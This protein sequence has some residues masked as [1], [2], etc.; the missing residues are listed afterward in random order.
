MG[1]TT[2]SNFSLNGHDHRNGVNGAAGNGELRFP[3]DFLWGAATAATQVEGHVRNEWTD[4]VARDG[5]N[6]RIAC[7]S[8]H[9]YP[10][11]VEWLTKLGVKGYR[12]GIEWSRLQPEPHGP[13]DPTELARYRDML[14]RLRAAGIEPM[15]VLHHFSN[16]PWVSAQGG[17]LSRKTVEAFTDYAGKLV[18]ALRDRVRIW[19]TFNEPDTYASNTYLLGEFP[20]FHKARLLAFRRVI[21]NMANAHAEACRLIRERG[22]GVGPVEVGFSKNWTWFQAYQGIFPWD[23]CLAALS[24]LVFNS[25][26]LRAFLGNG[27]ERASTFLGLNYYGRVRFHHGR[28]MVPINGCHHHELNGM[29]VM[30]DD[31]FERHPEG[32]E[33]VLLELRRRYSLP[34]YLTEHGAASEDEEFRARDLRENLAALHR[35]LGRGV[36]VRGFFYWSLLDNFEWQFGYSKKFGLVSVD[37]SRED[38][39]RAMKPLGHDY[40]RLCRENML[41]V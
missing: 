15:V 24:H 4:V 27:R 40:A 1:L 22:S 10:E 41:R 20:P 8:Y 37:F 11:D 5:S 29:G 32:L 28:A 3:K 2:A 13:L 25:F 12:V 26:V 14:D 39:P 23:Q 36:D 6:C 33:D 17:W 38:L 35:A 18:S 19:N 30:C 34:I 21:A 31:M 9:R 7:D 16:P